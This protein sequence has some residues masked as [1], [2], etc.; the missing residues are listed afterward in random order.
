MEPTKEGYIPF[1]VPTI[2]TPCHTFYKIFGDLA[3]GAPPVVFLHGGPGGGHDYLL[4]FASLWPR[5][6]LPV[7]LYD[8][9]GCGAS[10]HLPQTAGDGNFWTTALL[11]A[12]LNNLLDH[13]RLRLD[14][15]SGFHLVGQSCGGMF[16]AEFA[17]SSPRG[18]RKLVL[19]SSIAS[20]ESCVRGYMLLRAQAPPETQEALNEAERTG[21]WESEAAQ[22]AMALM[23]GK[24]VCRADPPPVELAASMKNLQ[25][26]R[27]VYRTMYVHVA[28]VWI[29]SVLVRSCVIDAYPARYGPS[30]LA[31]QGS[32]RGWTSV[33]DLHRITAQ[34]LVYNGEYDTSH[35]VTT[36]PYFQHIP[37]VRWITFPGSAHMCHSESKEMEN[38]I[39]S[40]VGDFL[41]QA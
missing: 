5:Y 6:G 14:D 27:T 3:S 36:V 4:P 20:H 33:P 31:F 7:V 26:D 12:E 30:W 37:R 18:L 19:A 34:T 28:P 16:G 15:G 8:Q 10:T 21:D 35:D 2:D 39:L 24:H 23:S 22:K 32:L 17:A 29:V 41:T 1:D 40:T 38:K 25:D 13:L 11:I 9:I